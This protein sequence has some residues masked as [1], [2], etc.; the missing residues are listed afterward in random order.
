MEIKVRNLTKDQRVKAVTWIRQGAPV[1]RG[2]EL[3]Y[4]FTGKKRLTDYIRANPGKESDLLELAFCT[5]LSITSEKF[6]S[7][8]QQYHEQKAAQKI[9]T[10]AHKVPVSEK[11]ATNNPRIFRNEF[12]F[13]SSPNCPPEL[14]ILAADKITAWEKYTRAHRYLF[15]CTSLEECF[16]VSRQLI[17]A[18]MDNQSIYEELIHFRDRGVVLGKHPIF[19]D[20][21]RQRKLSESSLVDLVTMATKTIPHRIW[22]IESEIKK[23]DKPHLLAE[24][25]QRLAEARSDLYRIRKMLN[26]HE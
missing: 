8:K 24:R 2:L 5:M 17:H 22:R 15:D 19:K 13:L 1:Q 18:Y 11:A 16:D 7:V 23:G 10:G 14:K 9:V 21:E 25:E 6:K 26:I 3:L 12:P 20:S 4:E